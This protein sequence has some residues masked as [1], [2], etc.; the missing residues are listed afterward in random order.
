MDFGY[1]LVRRQLSAPSGRCLLLA[2]SLRR[3]V[4][5][6]L[7]AVSQLISSDL[8]LLGDLPI[9]EALHQQ[10]HQFQLQPATR[11]AATAPWRFSCN[12]PYGTVACP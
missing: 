10:P 3:R 1:L 5:P 2:P 12:W 7:R 6:R 9:F 8:K 11:V 4:L